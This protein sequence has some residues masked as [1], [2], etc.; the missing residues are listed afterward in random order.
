MPAF[1]PCC[2]PQD[3]RLRLSHPVFRHYSCQWSSVAACPSEIWGCGADVSLLGLKAATWTRKQASAAGKLSCVWQDIRSQE[4][5]LQL[6]ARAVPGGTVKESGRK[7]PDREERRGTRQGLQPCRWVQRLSAAS[8]SCMVPGVVPFRSLAHQNS[9][10][11]AVSWDYYLDL[12]KI[13]SGV[14]ESEALDILIF[15]YWFGFQ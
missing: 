7:F 12:K 5:L 10:P 8:Q 13:L 3:F 9:H 2:A 6:W 14:L 11:W 1:A 15:V 4:P